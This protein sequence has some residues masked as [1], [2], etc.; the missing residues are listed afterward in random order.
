MAL[1]TEIRQALSRLHP[2]PHLQQCEQ[3]WRAQARQKF[4]GKEVDSLW[5]KARGLVPRGFLGASDGPRHVEAVFVIAE[6][7]EVRV[8]PLYGPVEAL[9]EE[10]YEISTNNLRV[11]QE[12]YHRK[13]K[14]GVLGR[15]F[16][17]AS[18]DEPMRRC[19]ITCSVYCSNPEPFDESKDAPPAVKRRCGR[20]HLVRG[21][22]EVSPC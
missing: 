7:S 1:P 15:F 16:P 8:Q 14:E 17:N 2:C 13:L 9:L 10:V 11:G 6:P 21:S 4:P 12:D 22:E 18:F 5:Q 19:F 3:D 20:L